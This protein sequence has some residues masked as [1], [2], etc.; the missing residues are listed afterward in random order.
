MKVVIVGGDVYKR[1]FL[2]LAKALRLTKTSSKKHFSL[3]KAKALGNTFG[4]CGWNLLW[5]FL[6][7]AICPLAT[8]QK[9]LA[10]MEYQISTISFS[11]D[12]EKRRKQSEDVYKRQCLYHA[13]TEQQQSQRAAH[14]VEHP[15]KRMRDGRTDFALIPAAQHNQFVYNSK[16]CEEHEHI[17]TAGK[18]EIQA[19]NYWDDK[20]RTDFRADV[21]KRQSIPREGWQSIRI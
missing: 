19:V 17:D 20:L 13:I 9:Q 2:N 14:C 12:L 4:H 18:K 6:K 3:Q 8:S 7:K 11:R 5:N 16:D 15:C 10:I 1:Q 21:Y